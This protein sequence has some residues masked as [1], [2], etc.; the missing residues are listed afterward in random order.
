MREYL[1]ALFTAQGYLPADAE[2]L[3]SVYDRIYASSAAAAIFDGALA[4]YDADEN[5]NY[6]EIIRAAD[7][8][9]ALLAVHPYTTELLVFLC[10]TRRL[11]ARYAERG[12]D[13]GIFYNTVLDL[14]YKLDECKLVYGTVGSFVAPWFVGFFNLTRFALG[15]LQF[16]LVPFGS[17]YERDGHLLTPDSRAINIHIPRSGEPLTPEACRAAYTLAKA[18]FAS[19]VTDPAPFVCNSWLLAPFHEHILPHGT[20]TY[21]FFASFEI[22]ESTPDKEGKN[23]WRLFDTMERNPARLPVDTTLRRAYVAHLTAG[24]SMSTA[25]GL[26]FF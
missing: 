12:L 1:T 16:E 22:L 24:G 2:Y 11:R 6:D 21:K 23:L 8:V 10:M 14:R 15:R 7:D 19:A 4:L 9:A 17:H 5:C 25:R 18:H 3:L 20:N 26:F 13:E